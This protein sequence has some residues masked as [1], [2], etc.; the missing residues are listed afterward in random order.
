VSQNPPPIP[1]PVNQGLKQLRWILVIV[2]LIGEFAL[3]SVALRGAVPPDETREVSGYSPWSEEVLEIA[4]AIPV[5]EGGRI[6]PLRTYARFKMMSF[7]GSLT[8]KVKSG[9][10][11]HKIGPVAWLLDCMFRPDLADQLPVFLLDDTEILKPFGIET[12]DRRA[13]LSFQD[14]EEGGDPEENGFTQL[15]NRGRELLEKQSSEGEG[16]LSDEEEEV[17]R[18]AQLA[19]NFTGIRDSMDIIRGG[20]PPLDPAQLA[21][22]DQE[23]YQTLRATMDP[24]QFGFWLPILPETVQSTQRLESPQAREFE[25]ELNRQLAFARFGP[26]WI[27]PQKGEEEEW[28][29][30]EAKVTKFLKKELTNSVEILKDFDKLEAI[31]KASGRPNSDEFLGAL[32]DWQTSLADRADDRAEG[33]SVASEVSYYRRDYFSNGLVYF[34]FAFL[35]SAVGWIIREGRGGKII[36]WITSIIYGIATAYVLGG[37]VHR[38]LITGRPPVS[39]LYDTIP[40]ITAGAVVILAIAELLTRR[41]VLLSLGAALGVIGLFFAASFE[42]G[43]A[44]DNM[45]P[46]RAVLDSNYWLATHVVSITIGYC[47]G[48][49]AC[50]LSLAYVHLA[51]AGV[52]K[53]QKSF[54]RFMTRTV[55]GITCFT[56]LFS[57]VGTILG[58]I[59]ANDSWGRFWGWDP[60]E[61]GALLIVLWCLIILHSRLAGWMTGW[62]LHIMSILGGSVV[63]FS[64]WGVNMLEVGLHSYGFIEGASTVYYFYFV[65]LVAT[66]VG[67]AAWLMERFSKSARVK[68]D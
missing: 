51:L 5:Q 16:S 48:L 56:L 11:I 12:E 68:T 32:K 10:K 1:A 4:E 29:T 53:D 8:M 37:L 36:A 54:H 59:W 63:V 46:L 17:T 39:N 35:V 20:L 64:W 38:Y 42:V 31:S 50:F 67:V 13:R 40:F 43:D 22:V 18:F 9:G 2:F 52:I 47:G 14:L 61:N 28:Q 41:K 60:K 30:I 27:P 58:G 25:Y 57:L 45:D 24:K 6:K 34:I 23:L 49:V 21:Y 65:T 19:L 26:A 44:K 66:G 55:Y 33:D 3:I 62:G 15:I 7:H